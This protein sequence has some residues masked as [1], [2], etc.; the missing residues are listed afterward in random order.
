MFELDGSIFNVPIALVVLI[1]SAKKV[2]YSI[3]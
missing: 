3:P 1:G 2:K